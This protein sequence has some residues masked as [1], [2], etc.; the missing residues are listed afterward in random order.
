M[1]KDFERGI[2]KWQPFNSC[3]NSEK[4]LS[5]I[6]NT[7]NRK[8]FPILSEDQIKNIEEKIIESFNLQLI[9]TITYYYDGKINDIMGQINFLDIT[10]KK[11]GIGKQIIYFKQ[12][13]N[14]I[15]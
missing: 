15:D 8:P 5:D 4:I 12:I 7:K 11:I 1:K 10:N 9:I 14:I 13:I 3:F 2:I 6:N